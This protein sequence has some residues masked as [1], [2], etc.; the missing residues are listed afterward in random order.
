MVAPPIRESR[1]PGGTRGH[2]SGTGGVASA[3]S[4]DMSRREQVARRGFRWTRTPRPPW[5]ASRRLHQRQSCPHGPC[6]PPW[7]AVRLAALP[8][9]AVVSV[10]G[11]GSEVT[12]ALGVA[13]G[14]RWEH[15]GCRVDGWGGV[16]AGS[17]GVKTAVGFG[18]RRG[19]F[20][21]ILP[22]LPWEPADEAFYECL[23]HRLRG[24]RCF[25]CNCQPQN[26]PETTVG[27][28]VP[29]LIRASPP[30]RS[31]CYFWACVM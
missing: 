4:V 6:W 13:G 16:A 3:R 17:G 8:V 27:R 9:L 29:Y 5:R 10:I 2:I 11:M 7:R 25:R 23:V 19:K 31:I 12:W 15:L 14:V 24:C 20:P 1:W 28:D 26:A 30:R 18:L 22:V 21:R